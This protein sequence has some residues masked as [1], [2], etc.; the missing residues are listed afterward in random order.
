MKV[1]LKMGDEQISLLGFI[2]FI[3]LYELPSINLHGSVYDDYDEYK[4]YEK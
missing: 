4:F 2:S 1:K 3:S